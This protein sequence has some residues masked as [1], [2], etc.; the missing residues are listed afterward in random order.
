MLFIEEK[1][2][3]VRKLTLSCSIGWGNLTQVPSFPY[4]RDQNNHEQ[5]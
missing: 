1:K 3:N 2:S 4:G 5:E